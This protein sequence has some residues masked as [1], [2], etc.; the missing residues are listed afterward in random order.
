MSKKVDLKFIIE[1]A[2]QNNLFCLLSIYN[3]IKAKRTKDIL[4]Q[5]FKGCSL[6]TSCFAIVITQVALLSA[7]STPADFYNGL[8][9]TILGLFAIIIGIYL[10]IKSSKEMKNIN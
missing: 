3:F 2:K 9:G 5:S 1:K 8:T 7:T 4:L 6:V 10:L